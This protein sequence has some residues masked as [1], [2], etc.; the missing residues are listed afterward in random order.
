MA[1]GDEPPP[2]MLPGVRSLSAAAPFA[3][4]TA[5]WRD[6][7]VHPMQSAFYGLFFATMGW[8]TVFTFRPVGLCGQRR[9][10]ADAD[11]VADPVAH[12]IEQPTDGC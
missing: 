12:L 2:A 10:G 9:G 1:P 11:P 8:L 4:L 3:W 7:R 5:A 6:Y